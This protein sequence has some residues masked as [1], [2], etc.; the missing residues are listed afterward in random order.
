MTTSTAA[1]AGQHAEQQ[2]AHLASH[3]NMMHEIMH[4]I[5]AQMNVLSFNQS[6]IEPGHV[7]G[8]NFEENGRCRHG[9]G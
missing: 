5:I 4:H 8:N 3:Q 1:N 9:H 6:N 2:F 7:V